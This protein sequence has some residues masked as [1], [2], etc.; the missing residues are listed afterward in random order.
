MAYSVF[1]DQRLEQ[2]VKRLSERMRPVSKRSAFRRYKHNKALLAQA[3][4]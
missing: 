4:N 3:D 1:Y 2:P